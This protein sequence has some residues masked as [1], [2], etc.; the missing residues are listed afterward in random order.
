MPAEL[1]RADYIVSSNVVRTLQ[2]CR[3]AVLDARRAV[4][5]L[6]WRGYDRIGILGTSLGSCLAMITAAHEPLVR[7]A[8]LNHVSLYFADVVW[9]GLSTSHVREG[10]QSHVDLPRLRRMWLPISPYTYVD[11]LRDRQSL[12]VYAKY[13][14]T[15]PL[16]L[17]R[18]LVQ[19]FRHRNVPHRVMVLP[20][21]HYST[22][23][24]PFKWM[25][26]FVLTRFLRETL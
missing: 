26:G 1:T 11:R 24:T 4:A 7:A 22:G 6:A 12:L 9:N 13:D 8:A 15:F 19:E 23:V 2:V 16:A 5:W 20:C 17:S 21:G 10:L 18:Q 25:D 14:L 3:Q